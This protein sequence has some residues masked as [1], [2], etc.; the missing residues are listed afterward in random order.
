M[1]WEV[2]SGEPSPKS[3]EY[4]AIVPSGSEEPAALNPTSSGALPL[5][6][7]AVIRATGNWLPAPADVVH[8]PATKAALVS[9]HSCTKRKRFNGSPPPPADHRPV[10]TLTSCSP[11]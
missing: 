9:R 7:V 3:H 5:S 6:G 8:A 11:A 2:S 1:F 4:D 10:G